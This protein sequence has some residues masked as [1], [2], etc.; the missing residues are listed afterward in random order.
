M[1]S[2]DLTVGQT[3]A[4][5]RQAPYPTLCTNAVGYPKHGTVTIKTKRSTIG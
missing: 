5:A 3:E 1:H 2:I 4:A